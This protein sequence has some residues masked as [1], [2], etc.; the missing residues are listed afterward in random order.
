MSWIAIDDV[1]GSILHSLNHAELVGPVNVVAPKPVTNAEFTKTLGRVLARPTIF[2]MP[3]F[4]AKLAFGQMG[5]ELLLGGQRV[6]PAKLE[7]TGYPFQYPEL[8]AA[9]RHVLA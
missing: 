8:E 6:K 2:P 3:A 9:L 1:I 5:E 7:Q 4:A